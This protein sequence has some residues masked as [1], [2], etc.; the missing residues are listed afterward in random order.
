MA[1]SKSRVK[2]LEQHKKVS[3][4]YSDYT[5]QLKGQAAPK[6]NKKLDPLTFI[7]QF[8]QHLL[9]AYFQKSR[10]YGLHASPTKKKYKARLDGSVQRNGRT[11]RTVMQ[12]LTQ[13][14]KENPFECQHCQS[15]E[16]RI[17]TLSAHRHWIYQN[18]AQLNT[19]K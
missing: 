1:I 3:I 15:I 6:A 7:N 16:Y 10:R 14:I 2:Y 4:L 8:L 12:I 9:P 18:V 5:N 19:T 13:L 17:E 11:I